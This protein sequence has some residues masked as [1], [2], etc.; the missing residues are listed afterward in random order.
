MADLSITAANV[1]IKGSDAVTKIVQFGETMTAGQ[2]TYLK[3]SDQKWWKADANASA[4]AAAASAIVLVG[5][6]GDAYGLV[7]TGGPMDLG[8][9]LTVGVPYIVS[10]TAGGIAPAPDFSGYSSSFLTHLG[11]ATAT[12]TIYIK[13]YVTGAAN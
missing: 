2:S 10:T 5:A 9:T 7:C 4:E 13:A 12:S 11:Y 8:A 3:A 6:A 1:K